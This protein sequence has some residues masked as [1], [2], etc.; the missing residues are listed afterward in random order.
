MGLNPCRLGRKW[1]LGDVS[2]RQR[3]AEWG[4]WKL[5]A[6]AC[7]ACREHLQIEDRAKHQIWQI[8]HPAPF[9]HYTTADFWVVWV[10]FC[11]SSWPLHG[12]LWSGG[13]IWWFR[14][15]FRGKN[16]A[17]LCCI[18]LS[19]SSVLTTTP[20]LFLIQNIVQK[21]QEW[22]FPLNGGSNYIPIGSLSSSNSRFC[23]IMRSW[24]MVLWYCAWKF[25]EVIDKPL[26]EWT[27][28]FLRIGWR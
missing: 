21:W 19:S 22:S 25:G 8:W 12:H 27:G 5:A 20:Q 4:G 16:P 3:S 17:V 24:R 26:E 28:K 2:C 7:N 11:A 18:K 14:S 6:W 15:Y 9:L 1:S 13:W 23:Y 10:C